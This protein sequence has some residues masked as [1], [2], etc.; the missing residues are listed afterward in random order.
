MGLTRRG[1]FG[2]LVAGA[3]TLAFVA[4]V[5]TAGACGGPCAAADY[6]GDGVNDW[7]D[8]CPLRSNLSQRDTDKDTPPPLIDIGRPA[9]L[10]N[11]PVL[12]YDSPVRVYPATPYQTAQPLPTDM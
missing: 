4:G 3:V 6:D 1:A 8:N 2:W 10:P 9:G 11:T 7:A 12:S 5:P